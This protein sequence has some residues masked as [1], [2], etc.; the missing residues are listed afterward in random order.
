M[1]KPGKPKAERPSLT[2]TR[3]GPRARAAMERAI[4]ARR[5]APPRDETRRNPRE[6]EGRREG[7]WN[8]RPRNPQGAPRGDE[9][10]RP[11]RWGDAPRG[12]RDERDAPRRSYR[13]DDVRRRT[14]D[15]FSRGKPAPRRDDERP[16]FERD[17]RAP[18]G[19][20]RGEGPRGPRDGE[21]P[22]YQGDRPRYEGDR[23]R[24][25]S[26]RPRHE[27]D[28]PR[29]GGDRPRYQGDRPR[30]DGRF[31]GNS[32]GDR[33]GRDESRPRD[34]RQWGDRPPRGEGGFPRDERPR[35]EGSYP[36][37]ERPRG[38]GGFNRE[39]APRREGSFNRDERP[40]GPG[41]FNRDD[42]PRRD[43]A[44]SRDERPRSGGFERDER[45]RREGGGF[46]R[47]ERPREGG[48]NRDGQARREGGYS[49]DGGG[50][51]AR[52]ERPRRS[53]GPAGDARGPARDDRGGPRTDRPARPSW[54]DRP[55]RP[56]GERGRYPQPPR[57]PGFAPRTRR[58]EVEEDDEDEE[59]DLPQG[60][61]VSKLMAARGICSR[62][63]ADEYIERGWVFVNGERVKELGRRT[64]PDAKITLAPEAAKLQGTRMTILLHKPIGFVSGQPEDDY[65][66]AASLITQSSQ[67]RPDGGPE[68]KPAHFHGLAPAG[69][70]DIDST[71]LLVLTQ[72]G[73]VARQL[74]GEDS[75]V[76][77][78]YL[79]RVE[80]ELSAEGLALL[81]H[82]LELD[83]KELR[84]AKVE[85]L[86]EDQ[87]RFVLREGRKR[88]I[89]R[90]CELVGLKV[91]GLKRIRIGRV[92]LGDLPQGQW[93]FLREDESFE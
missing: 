1:N 63:E 39:Q 89:R 45:P 21:R 41:G 55:P 64:E 10:D 38:Q 72:D 14:G 84:P 19:D 75:T 27:G 15:D 29:E 60:V 59:D 57:D 24:A 82:G 93:R 9:R 47:D 78:E 88:Q 85:W 42:A 90:M 43:G 86:N 44:Y 3:T 51:Y 91:T 77:K 81:N 61:R 46:N 30:N 34:Q 11:Q 17:D 70:L 6:D 49:R 33:G 40:R 16:R 31:E 54:G 7:G 4:A 65:P 12:G 83:G 8:D 66:P 58:H 5:D 23:S 25:P 18:R 80:G 68:L 26:D 92:V 35:R 36:R 87:L 32:Q 48:Y 50:A 2:G 79:V 28:R 74:I 53:E 62:R 22:R 67:Y 73:R 20:N 76:E 69:R 37:D 52:D 13:D 56:S 71:G